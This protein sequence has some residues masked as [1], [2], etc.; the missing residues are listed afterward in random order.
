[1]STTDYPDTP[2]FPEVTGKVSA[3]EFTNGVA[4]V[5][6]AA[7]REEVTPVL[8]A[9]MITASSKELTMVSTDRFRVA[10]KVIPWTGKIS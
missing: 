4:K 5:V 2:D 10:V 8:T 6:V 7:S 9:V 1:M 3:S